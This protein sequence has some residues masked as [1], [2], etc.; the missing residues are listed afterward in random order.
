MDSILLSLFFY[1]EHIIVVTD[2]IRVQLMF[3][4]GDARRLLYSLINAH[5]LF[6]E[7]EE[8]TT[9]LHLE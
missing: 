6:N 7:C 9:S 8:N 1:I 3:I 2:S 5:A 4:F